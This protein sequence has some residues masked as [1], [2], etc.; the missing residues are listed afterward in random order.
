MDITDFVVSHRTD[1]L[2]VGNYDSYRAQLTRRLHALRKRLGRVTPK[3][4]KYVAHA[5]VTAEDVAG[6]TE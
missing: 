5:Q 4:K 2:L 1:A 6:N 3:N